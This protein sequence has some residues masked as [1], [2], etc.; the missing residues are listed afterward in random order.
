M[1]PYPA[2]SDSH[3]DSRLHQETSPVCDHLAVTMPMSATDADDGDSTAFGIFHGLHSHADGPSEANVILPK[4][5]GQARS[6]STKGCP[7][8]IAV[9]LV[10]TEQLRKQNRAP[11][12]RDSALTEQVRCWWI[13]IALRLGLVVV[14]AYI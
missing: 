8:P 2:A 1:A 5:K 11:R 10:E 12:D 14:V 7:L 3:E 6:A 4:L 13:L 9:L